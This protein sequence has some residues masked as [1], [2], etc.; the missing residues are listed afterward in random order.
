MKQ[1]PWIIVVL[2]LVHVFAPIGNHIM[3]GYLANITYAEY[4]SL[5]LNKTYLLNNWIHFIFPI[6]AGY[7][8]Y[9]C[10]KWS[11]LS[12]LLCMIILFLNSYMNYVTRSG[13]MSLTSLVIIYIFNILVVVY[14][15]VPSVRTIYSLNATH[16]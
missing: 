16:C 7:F 6:M 15:L 11:L 4:F 2:A 5:T 1:R 12:Y 9:Q 8:I 3:N 13:T 10:K 14:F